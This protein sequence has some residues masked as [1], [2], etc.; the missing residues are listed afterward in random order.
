MKQI[1]AIVK[2]FVVER[3]MA[4]IIDHKIDNVQ[5]RTVKGFGRQKN[6]LDRYGE[7]ESVRG[8]H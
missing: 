4:A 7:N 1:V 3:V 8:R 2:P 5:I 6:Y